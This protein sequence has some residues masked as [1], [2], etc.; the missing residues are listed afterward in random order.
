[1]YIRRGSKIAKDWR[2]NLGE[3]DEVQHVLFSTQSMQLCAL[4]SASIL[5]PSVVL[6]QHPCHFCFS[7]LLGEQML[8]VTLSFSNMASLV[9]AWHNASA[10]HCLHYCQ[11]LLINSINPGRTQR[12]SMH[13]YVVLLLH[14]LEQSLGLVLPDFNVVQPSRH[15]MHAVP[16]VYLGWYSPTKHLATT[17]R[18]KAKEPGGASVKDTQ[19]TAPGFERHCKC[20]K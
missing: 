11:Q 6:W 10:M 7:V 14:L 4:L 19:S 1:M 8:P 5:S 12:N 13:K 9:V 2:V 15:G 18:E 16:M 20:C 17:F 3:C